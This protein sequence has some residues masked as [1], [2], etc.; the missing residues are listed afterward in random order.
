MGTLDAGP[1]LAHAGGWDEFLFF[2]VPVLAAIGAIRWANARS[3][4][5]DDAREA[6]DEETDVS[7]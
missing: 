4:R 7:R 1:V 5:A 2:V 6:D 3:K